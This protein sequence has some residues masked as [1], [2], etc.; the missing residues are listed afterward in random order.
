M[1]E[2]R[3]KAGPAKGEVVE[4]RQVEY[5]PA[6]VGVSPERGEPSLDPEL[7]K[8]RDEE[9]KRNEKVP[10]AAPLGEPTIDPELVKARKADLEREAKRAGVNL[11]DTSVGKAE[12]TDT[13]ATT[14]KKASSSGKNK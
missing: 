13:K 12:A 8:I 3:K 4:T 14:A 1:A 11:A 5:L 7:A 9:I 6:G 2:A 10:A